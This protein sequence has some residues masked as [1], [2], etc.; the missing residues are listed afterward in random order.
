M[1]MS[2]NAASVGQTFSFHAAHDV[3]TADGSHIALAKG[4]P[5][6]GEV[7]AVDS[8]GGN[9]HGGKISLQFNWIVATDGTKVPLTNAQNST[10]GGDNKGGSSTA[11][12]ATY[13]LLGPLG[14][15]AHNFVRGRDAQI[16]TTTPLTAYVDRA[17]RPAPT[18]TLPP[19]PAPAMLGTPA[20]IAPG[21]PTS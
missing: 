19:A 5:G 14:L 1:P 6:V 18:S 7:Q 3:T 20:P 12:I 21:T 17:L 9:G 13:L 2:S 15:F 4:A 8:A 16:S 10:E 11:T